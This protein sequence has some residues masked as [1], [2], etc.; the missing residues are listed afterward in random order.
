MESAQ[1]TGIQAEEPENGGQ[2]FDYQAF[3]QAQDD[4]RIQRMEQSREPEAKRTKP[5]RLEVIR[6][7]NPF[8]DWEEEGIEGWADFVGEWMENSLYGLLKEHQVGEVEPVVKVSVR[9]GSKGARS[10]T[11]AWSVQRRKPAFHLHRTMEDGVDT[12]A[13]NTHDYEKRK[14]GVPAFDKIRY[15]RDKMRARLKDRLL[16]YSCVRDSLSGE[17]RKRFIHGLFDLWDELQAMEMN[18]FN[19]MRR[20]ARRQEESEEQRGDEE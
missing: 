17:E 12:S 3:W 13:F 20:E 19:R 18:R 1:R 14:A 2:G 11:C 15:A 6:Q 7:N 16:T 10:M 8:Q 4:R 5:V 9:E